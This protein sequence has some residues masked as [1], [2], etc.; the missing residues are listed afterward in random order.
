MKELFPFIKLFK[1]QSQWMIFGTL[2]SWSA[3]LM[4]I[5]LMSLSGWFISIA[6]YLAT[7]SY[8]VASSFNYFYPAGGVRTFS[9]G[10]ICARYG[11][12]LLTHEATFKILTDVRVWFYQKLEPLAP[13]HLMKYKTGD[14]L[15]RIVNDIGVLDNLYIRIISPTIVLLLSCITVFIFFCF[16]SFY[17]AITVSLLAL[18][19]GLAIPF[20]SDKLSRKK[21]IILNENSAQLKTTVVEHISSLAEIK[22]FDLDNTSLEKIE[23]EN[24]NLL[25]SESKLSVKTGISSALMTFF[26]GFTVVIATIFAVK[27]TSDNQ[28]NGAFIALIALGVMALFEAI[29]PLPI[30]YQYLGKTISASKRILGV[31][32]TKP[33]ILYKDRSNVQLNNFD[34]DFK[35]VTFSYDNKKNIF[36]NFNL[37]IKT[38]EKVALFAPTGSGKTTIINLIARFWDINAG[39]IFIGNTNIKEFSEEQLRNNM[40]I[41]SQSPHI[42][43]TSIKE[44]LLLANPNATDKELYEALDKVKM[45]EFVE[46]LP[47]KLNSWTGEYGSHLSGGQQKRIAVARAFLQ[48]KPILIMDE[49][50]EGLDKNTEKLVFANIQRLMKNKTVIFITHNKNLIKS[51]DKI[52]NL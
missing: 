18:F 1:N 52:I 41:I 7:T 29:M 9:L 6:G 5:G 2:L 47:N 32:D 11:E 46:N 10:R 33:N 50:T 25:A 19:I 40:T 21:S 26:M 14:L 48:D 34:I 22:I 27:L 35:D 42:F 37:N 15:N 24:K 23:I 30:A 38:N 51:F 3:I 4:S 43:N 17:L 12:R 28:I 20:I 45:K 49:P 8:I 39:K 36:E 31:I 44:N 13:S 16:F